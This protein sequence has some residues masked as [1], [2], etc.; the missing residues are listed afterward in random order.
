MLYNALA[1][2]S[3]LKTGM[4]L[5]I[6]SPNDLDIAYF[7]ADAAPVLL[8]PEEVIV[9]RRRLSDT[10]LNNY[11]FFGGFRSF[12]RKTTGG[13]FAVISGDGM[14]VARFNRAGDF[15][16]VGDIEGIS[17]NNLDVEMLEDYALLDRATVTANVAYIGAPMDE[18]WTVTALTP[19][20]FSVAGETSG[21]TANAT[22]SVAYDNGFIRFTMT[23]GLLA[24][25]VGD[26][27]YLTT[28]SFFTLD[29]LHLDNGEIIKGFVESETGTQIVLKVRDSFLRRRIAKSQLTG[30]TREALTLDRPLQ[31]FDGDGFFFA[32]RRGQEPRTADDTQLPDG[33]LP[34]GHPL[35]YPAVKLDPM[36]K[37]WYLGNLVTG[38]QTW[39]DFPV[40]A[41][42]VDA[43]DNKFAFSL[44]GQDTVMEI[45]WRA[46]GPLGLDE[47]DPGF[48]DSLTFHTFLKGDAEAGYDIAGEGS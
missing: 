2:V 48:D 24:V 15:G 47:D 11:L 9:P 6:P 29:T 25:E 37:L 14:Y 34:N 41:V 36:G 8:A 33:V 3:D 10:Y 46:V 31:Y 28:R 19:T 45:H 17:W 21:A 4:V 40:E 5:N 22:L 35:F 26:T 30:R 16:F 18:R 32:V 44:N 12:I 38:G 7:N 20:T 43:D 1:E 23:P 39:M 27:Y 42:G 13:E